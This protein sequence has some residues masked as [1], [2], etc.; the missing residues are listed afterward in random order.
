M[1]THPIFESD[2]DCLT[3]M[4]SV[5]EMCDKQ[6]WLELFDFFDENGD[7]YISWDEFVNTNDVTDEDIKEAIE[8]FKEADANGDG[9]VSKD[10]FYKLMCDWAMKLERAVKDVVAAVI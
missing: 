3:D 6:L 9:K 1:G 8:A 4:A 2:F 10:E 5:D 7:G